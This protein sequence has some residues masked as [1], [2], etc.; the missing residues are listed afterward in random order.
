MTTLTLATL[1]HAS[2]AAIRAEDTDSYAEAHRVTTRT[3]KPMVVMVTASWCAPCQKMKKAVLP[4]C[5]RKGLFEPVTFAIVDLDRQKKLAR[6]LTGGGSV[7]QLIM[8]RKSADG[9]KRRRL[10][11]GQS[12]ESVEQFVKEGLA[13]DETDKQAAAEQVA[14]QKGRSTDGAAVKH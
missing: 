12:V 4:E 14:K 3:G 7:P 8:Y 10:V 1:L 9:W 13:L 2:L 5:Q 11:G 6:Q